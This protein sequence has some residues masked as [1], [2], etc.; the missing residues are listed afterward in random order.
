MPPH[1]IANLE[2]QIKALNRRIK[3]IAE[4]DELQELLR[5]I[6]GPGWTTPA[7]FKLVTSIV[8]ALDAHVRA[9]GALKTNLIQGSRQISAIKQAA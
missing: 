9:I 4:D 2:K 3:V 5:H 7:E 6:H 1:D 8:T